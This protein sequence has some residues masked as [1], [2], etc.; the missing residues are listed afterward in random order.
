MKHI[1]FLTRYHPTPGG[2]TG[3]TK[4][5]IKNLGDDYNFSVICFRRKDLISEKISFDPSK[6]ASIKTLEIKKKFKSDTLNLISY[7]IKSYKILKKLKDKKELDIIIGTGLSGLGGII[8]GKL[9][10]IPA[11]FNTSGIR[12]RNIN[13]H[14]DYEIKNKEEKEIGKPKLKNYPRFL[15]NYLTDRLSILLSTKTT[16][17]TG[18]LEEQLEKNKPKL[19]KKTKSKFKVIIEG[20]NT[21]RVDNLKKEDILK[22][23]N[24]PEGKII[25]FSRIENEEFFQELFKEIKKEIPD[26]TVI[27]IDAQRM[28]MRLEKE[29]KLELTDMGPIKAMIASDLMLCIP[30]TEPH[31]TLV[32]ESLYTNCPTF[33]SNVGWLKYEFKDYPEFI[34]KNLTKQE[35]IFKIKDFYKNRESYSEKFSKIKQEILD[36]NSFERTKKDY[37]DLFDNISSIR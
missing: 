4:D 22:E 30:G 29:G 11:I 31:S 3:F 32:L 7:H 10:K 1:V 13:E 17:P 6:E 12:G 27:S 14:I 24:I 2:R 36:R 35:T 15:Y 34:V 21:N 37:K 16:I 28:T 5:I 33:V 23:Y 18:H 9:N 19:Y 26:S 8:F 25:L 20:L